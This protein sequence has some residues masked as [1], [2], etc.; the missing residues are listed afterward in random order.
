MVF[1]VVVVGG[2]GGVVAWHKKQDSRIYLTNV[3]GI[4]NIINDNHLHVNICPPL[5]LLL[6]SS[7]TPREW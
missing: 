3:S 2:V 1:D 7:L 6:S 4:Y 5:L